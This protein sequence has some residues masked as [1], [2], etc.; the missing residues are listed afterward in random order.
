MADF[1]TDNVP[2]IWTL[3]DDEEKPDNHDDKES[4]D[5]DDEKKDQ[6]SELEKPSFL[7]RLAKRYK[8]QDKDDDSD[9]RF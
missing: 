4:E 8:N 5:K 7:R 9:G 6:D 2:N 1:K 3:E